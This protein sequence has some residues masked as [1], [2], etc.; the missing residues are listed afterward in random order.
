MSS[1]PSVIYGMTLP[2]SLQ[3]PRD[4]DILRTAEL[5]ACLRADSHGI[6]DTD[7]GLNQ[8]MEVLSELNLLVTKW[9]RS[10]SRAKNLPP[11]SVDSAC[12]KIYTFGSFRLGIHT[13][14]A[15]IDTLCI[16]PRHVDRSDFFSSFVE[17]L[18]ENSDIT[19]IRVV[20]DAY[21]PVIKM[22]L[23]G[24]ELDML[25]A[26]LA[27]KD[28]PDDL[29]LG[30]NNLLKNLDPRCV[31]SLNGCRVTDEIL[32][33]VPDCETFR[34]TLRAVR[35][36]AKRRGIYSNV[37]GYLGGVSWAML[38]ART[39]QLYPNAAPSTLVYKFFLV[40]SN[41]EWPKPV[42]LRQP[43]QTKLGF[44]IWDP[45]LNVS[46]R[47]H[48]MPIITP[49]YPQ[50]NSTFNVT[51]STRSIMMEAFKSGL[52][53]TDE[54]IHG[55]ASWERL[56]DP[57]K[58]FNMYKHLI[59]VTALCR[60]EEEL[61]DWQGLV[62]SRIR[63][64]V[65]SLERISVISLAHVYPRTYPSRDPETLN[66]AT[67]WFIGLEFQKDS[68]SLDL[69]SET[70]TFQEAVERHGMTTRI[71]K[72]GMEVQV[73][74][75]RRKNLSAY[76]PPED[77]PQP[78]KSASSSSSRL[79]PIPPKPE[80]GESVSCDGFSERVNGDAASSATAAADVSTSS[81]PLTIGVKR[82]ASSD[83]SSS[84]EEPPG[85]D[86]G[87]SNDS[88]ERSAWKRIRA[89]AELVLSPVPEATKPEPDPEP[90]LE[91]VSVVDDDDLEITYEKTVCAG[92]A[93]LVGLLPRGTQIGDLRG[94]L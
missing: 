9:V 67:H 72:E 31:R 60:N 63:H 90:E 1:A 94:S 35:L 44:P 45:R 78:R 27:L 53:I 21:V 33:L 17:L 84:G 20:E 30:D 71:F 75:V 14:G 2:V 87:G 88:G 13:R 41:W 85:S 93:N 47:Y 77:V 55:R 65:S 29:E 74:Y 8:R 12:G 22:N 86:T 6:F 19:A 68:V 64:L 79:Q 42:V 69:S 54:I 15:D 38:V 49:A 40:F 59:V 32:R 66:R 52:Q 3:G 81:S 48:L 92:N 51:T 24:I 4:T 89:A 37:L 57:I 10:V 23:K 25:F 62:E 70:H 91:V 7:E 18:R 34:L 43:D 5:E 80:D 50:Q 58:F 73:N 82:V 56:F 61:L 26:R 39:C 28:I 76:L 36:W 46:D 16:A 83:Q 11:Q